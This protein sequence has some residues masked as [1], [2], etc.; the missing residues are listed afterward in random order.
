MAEYNQLYQMARYYDIALRRD[1]SPEVDFMLA[2]YRHYVRREV[3]AMIDIACG[4]GYHARE[5]ARRGVQAFGLDL[6][7]EMVDFAHEQA[8]VEGVEVTGLVADMCC[9]E[10]SQ[11]VDLAI[12]IFDGLDAL[13]EN[14]VIVEHLRT[15]AA[16]LSPQGI[17]LLEHTHPQFS[18]LNH[19]GEFRY[20]GQVNGTFVDILWAVNR[21]SFNPVTNVAEVEIEVR[22]HEGDQQQIFRDSARERLLLPQELA[23]LVEQSQALQIVGCYGD[24]NLNQPFDNSDASNRMITVLQKL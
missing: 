21:P 10:L 24:F 4:P 7:P 17:Y 8:K 16:H 22:V 23:I 12:C 11:P 1:V 19:Y 18:S 15:V 14:R 20:S 5:F 6:R 9:F 2:V 3:R 13:L